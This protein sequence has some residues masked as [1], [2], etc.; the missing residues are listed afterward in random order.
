M[1]DVDSDSAIPTAA[2]LE[3]GARVERPDLEGMHADLDRQMR[4][5]SVRKVSDIHLQQVL[6]YALQVEQ[7]AA[8]LRAALAEMRQEA[9]NLWVIAHGDNCCWEDECKRPGRECQWPMPAILG[10]RE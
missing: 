4:Y 2:L 3:P 1:T 7:D 5:A 8:G 10:A 6:S 9:R